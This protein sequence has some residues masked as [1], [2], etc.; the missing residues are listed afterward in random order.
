MNIV[1]KAKKGFTIVELVIVI[2]VIGILS[3]ILIPT[4]VNV[5]KN[6]QEAALRSD[7][8]SSYSMYIADAAED[9]DV[10]MFAQDKVYLSKNATA[11]TITS[12]DG[13]YVYVAN[14]GWDVEAKKDPITEPSGYTLAS[15]NGATAK[16]YGQ[17][18]VYALIED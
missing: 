5:T 18:Y 3:A 10:A 13:Y 8:A 11:A 1:K 17:F 15:V 16:L 7:L 2:G 4:F 14:K 9:D 6:A 12:N